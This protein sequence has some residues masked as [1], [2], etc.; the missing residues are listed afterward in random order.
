[1]GQGW[2]TRGKEITMGKRREGGQGRGK[3]MGGR[4]TSGGGR[5]GEGSGKCGSSFACL[6][7]RRPQVGFTC[8]CFALI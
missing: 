7:A 2:I 3:G 1:M 8:V 4:G 5:E 6:V